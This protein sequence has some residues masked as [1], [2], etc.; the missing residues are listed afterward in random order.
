MKVPIVR[1]LAI[2]L[3]MVA[4]PAQGQSVDESLATVPPPVLADSAAPG[5]ISTSR[6]FLRTAAAL[7]GSA[8]GYAYVRNRTAANPDDVLAPVAAG[9]VASALGSLIFTNA[10][11]AKVLLGSAIATL[12]SAALASYLA[13]TLE[14][15][16]QRPYP[17]IAFTIPQ[18]LLTSAFAQHRSA[19]R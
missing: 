3:V 9:A 17:M 7:A 5:Q 2:A 15:D 8:A 11:P 10:H 19:R 1:V 12:P 18:G 14:D 6:P 13:G 4:S 16:Q